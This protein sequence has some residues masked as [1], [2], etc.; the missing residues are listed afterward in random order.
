MPPLVVTLIV[1]SALL[2]A[3]WNAA[4]KRQHD[5]EGASVAV[6]AV[7]ALAA[8]GALPLSAG[9]A[10]PGGSG[11]AWSLAAGLCE[12]GYFITLGLAFRAAPLGIV[13]TVA[14]GGALVAVWPASVLWMG[15][16]LTPR[17]AI[18]TGLLLAGLG[19]VGLDRRG[20]ASL[21]G[22]LWA[23][24][25]AIFIA[26]YHLA[27]KCAL[28]T[29]A[30]PV[31]VFATALAVAL[32]VN[33]ARLGLGE[34]RRPVAA[35]RDSPLLV[36]AAG[37][38]CTASFLVFLSALARGGAGA[39]VTLRNTSVLFALLLAWLLG[40]RPGRPQ[41]VGTVSVAL[42]AVVMGWPP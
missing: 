39:A 26:G 41:V 37:L 17:L 31:G 5:P 9:P 18:G 25:C 33:V 22:L 36:V 27:Y 29:G 38:L 16:V 19:L 6:L 42:G 10:F 12:G 8:F 3:L 1:A 35:L 28:E 20:R 11:L 24:L 14:R 13:Y 34:L 32:P 30:A 7:A 40:E 15:E 4:L 2:H 23:L 21:Q